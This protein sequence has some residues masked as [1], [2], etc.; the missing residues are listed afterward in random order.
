MNKKILPPILL[1]FIPF[2]LAFAFNPE[3]GHG[4]SGDWYHEL[5]HL[6]KECSPDLFEYKRETPPKSWTGTRN[7]LLKEK[8][9]SEI[10]ELSEQLQVA[11]NLLS[12]IVA[13]QDNA[14]SSLFKMIFPPKW[15]VE[16]ENKQIEKSIL[17]SQLGKKLDRLKRS[18]L[19]GKVNHANINSYSRRN[20][21]LPIDHLNKRRFTYIV[22]GISGQNLPEGHSFD[23]F[24]HPEKYLRAKGEN[25]SVSIINSHK[26][27][28]ARSF[29]YILDV[30]KHLIYA[31]YP[32]NMD[33]Y[34]KSCEELNETYG[35]PSLETLLRN[36]KAN[37]HNE[38][39]IKTHFNYEK[40]VLFATKVSGIFI[41]LKQYRT[42][43]FLPSIEILKKIRHLCHS[44]RLPVIVL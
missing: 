19:M 39:C 42:S 40:H 6:E 32:H 24:T 4:P 25:L 9:K 38:A 16:L 26:H 27:S 22:H 28:T 13:K 14:P 44:K 15:M 2:N 29:G 34:G 18:N 21:S 20:F 11:K 10:S 35:L 33:R 41:N 23:L 17:V 3:I 43:C 1:F 12:Q 8:K 5:H 7:K 37:H 30:P 31:S 36:S